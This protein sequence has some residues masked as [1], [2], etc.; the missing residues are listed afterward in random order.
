MVVGFLK[1]ALGV[2]ILSVAASLPFIGLYL[3]YE[4]CKPYAKTVFARSRRTDETN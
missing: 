2:F 1:T 3:I 4:V